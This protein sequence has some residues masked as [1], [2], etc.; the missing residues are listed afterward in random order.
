MQHPRE[1]KRFYDELQALGVTF[2]NSP[3]E[4]T[5]CNCFPNAYEHFTGK[6]PKTVW[7]ES[8]EQI[9][10]DLIKSTFKEFMLKDYVKS[11]K[12][13]K[14][15]KSFKTPVTTEQMEPLLQEFK[16]IRGILFTGDS[17]SKSLCN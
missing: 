8:G 6:T 3:D 17:F 2:I 11:V 4:Y 10:W 7:F 1:Y 13:N 16:F 5:N 15:P 9:D 14:F 12:E